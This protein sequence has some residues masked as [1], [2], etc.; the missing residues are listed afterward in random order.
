M[1]GLKNGHIRE[2]V[3]QNGE[4]QGYSWGTQKMKKKK[5]MKKKK[6]KNG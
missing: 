3:T 2:N 5:E 1:V 4:P 6:K